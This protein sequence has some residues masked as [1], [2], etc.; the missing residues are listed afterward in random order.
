M[1]LCEEL[2]IHANRNQVMLEHQQFD[3]VVR[4][5]NAALQVGLSISVF[6]I[7]LSERD[8]L[9]LVSLFPIMIYISKVFI[10]FPKNFFNGWN[11]TE[12]NT[13]GFV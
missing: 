9:T 2:G 4:L 11:W 7:L 6:W 1:A 13:C 3:L 12:H 10:F 8:T 5:L